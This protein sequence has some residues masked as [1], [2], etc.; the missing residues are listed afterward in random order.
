LL[1]RDLLSE[2]LGRFIEAEID[3][4][5]ADTELLYAFVTGM[6]R[7]EV[8]AASLSGVEVSPEVQQ[9]FEALAIRREQREP[10]QH[11]TG[12]AHFRH[13]TLSV[14]KGVFVPRPE[15]ELLAGL[16]IDFLKALDQPELLA[17]DLCT[18]SG[19]VALSVANE[20]PK[21]RVFGIEKSEDAY[22]WAERNFLDYPNAGLI[23]GDIA[24]G[25]P[26]F[27]GLVDVV[28][29]N[30]PYIPVGMVPI[31]PEVALHD[32]ELALYGGEDG[33]DIVR[34]AERTAH[35][36]LREGGFFAVEHADIQAAA[37]TELLLAR[38]WHNVTS[39]QDFNGRDRVV[40]AIR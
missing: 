8:Q 38:G 39:N 4:A 19:A 16:G 12:A 11:L 29:S 26:A 36:L 5:A 7:G 28:L 10:L 6:S 23:L 14:G 30:P 1:L 21:A 3:S 25:A 13:I 27:N 34:V 17:F 15:T 31:Y 35:D 9:Q 37:I 33:L 18:G 24:N 20:V 22:R 32:P 40:S 2:W